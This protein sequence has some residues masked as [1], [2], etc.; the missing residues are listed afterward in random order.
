MT[1]RR[2]GNK[3]KVLSSAAVVLGMLF[4]TI[5]AL[6]AA[7]TFFTTTDNENNAGTGTADGDMADDAIGVRPRLCSRVSSIAGLEWRGEER[8]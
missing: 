3:I 2:L 1:T 7:G 4:I 8:L 6:A 5:T